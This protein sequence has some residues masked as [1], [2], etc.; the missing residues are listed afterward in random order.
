MVTH[1]VVERLELLLAGGL[2]WPHV[3]A[4]RP[5]RHRHR[6][7]AAQ[8][9]PGRARAQA[10][11]AAAPGCHRGGGGHRLELNGSAR[12]S[13]VVG[14]SLSCW[15]WGGTN[16]EG[17]E[18]VGRGGSAA[19]SEQEGNQI[20]HQ[21][22]VVFRARK[23]S[24]WRLRGGHIPAARRDGEG[25]EEEEEERVAPLNGATA[26]HRADLLCSSAAAGGGWLD[27]IRAGREATPAR[28][29]YPDD[30]AYLRRAGAWRVLEFELLSCPFLRGV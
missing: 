27:T 8:P 25:E 9:H 30:R 20:G 22:A 7:G 28:R 12:R 21:L 29:A 4:G 2:D 13:R 16:E 15:C 14:L 26:S 17:G 1:L 3:E 23:P 11:D 10:A 19:R 6:H 18:C 5:L 24:E